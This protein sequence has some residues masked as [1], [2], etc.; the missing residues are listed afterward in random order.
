MSVYKAGK[1]PFWQYDFKLRGGGRFC[2]SFNG[3][4]GRPRIETDRPK[5]EAERAEAIIRAN[6]GQPTP[7]K[8]RMTL[9]QA[10]S[11]YWAEAACNFADSSGEWG[12]LANLER[13]LGKHTYFDEI[14]D[15]DISRFVAKRRTETAR[16]KKTPVSPAT[17]NRELECFGR[18]QKRAIRPWKT[19]LPEDPVVLTTHKLKEP[20]ERIRSLTSDEDAALFKAIDKIRPDFRDMLEFALLSGKRLSEVICLEKRKVDRRAMEARAIQ[21]GGQEI[22]IALTDASL[23]ILERNWMHHAV[24]VFTY[25]CQKNH[26]GKKHTHRK[27]QR[28]PFTQDG[29]RKPWKDILV[30][31]KI[32]DFRFHDLRHTTGTRVLTATGNLKAV[33]DA[34]SHASIASSARYAHTDASQRR[35]ALEA[36]ERLRIPETSR[37]AKA[38]HAKK[39]G[40]TK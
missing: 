3:T 29:W 4:N 20:S 6:A 14:T 21:K 8:P 32:T 40:G 27:D 19:R 23:A 37:T 24:Y 2:G 28:Y 36:A 22:V 11:K 38:G 1:S 31:A 25:V 5:R 33:Q 9:N 26:T 7:S 13:H 18:I 17:V 16:N 34:L 12:R 10:T 30:E 39:K 15:A 35:S